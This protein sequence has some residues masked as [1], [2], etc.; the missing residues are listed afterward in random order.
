VE[1]S[2]KLRDLLGLVALTGAS[3]IINGYHPFSEDSETYLPAI[4]KLLNPRLFPVGTE[5]FQMHAHM[6]LFPRL[7]A[8]TVQY[9]HMSLAWA[10][11]LWQVISFFLFILACWKLAQ[12]ILP[13][14]ASCWA[15]VGLVVAL[16]TMPVAGTSLYLMDPFLNPRNIIAF[17]MV[18]AVL[19]VIE[20]RYVQASLFFLFGISVHPFM[21]AFSVTFCMLFVVMDERAVVRAP[22]IAVEE[23]EAEAAPAAPAIL[24]ASSF[25]GLFKPPSEAYD[26]VAVNH[27]YQF[28]ARWTWYEMLGAIAPVFIF[29]WF[30]A[31][32]HAR[33]LRNL[34]LLSRAMMIYGAVYFAIGLIVSVP[35]R[36]EVLSLL[37]PMRSLYLLYV[38]MLL[39][40]GGLL[41]EYLL[42]NRVWRWVAL[43]LPLSAGM[44]YAQR[45]L[46]PESSHIELPG[47][48]PANAWA[49]AF[50]WVRDNT[51]EQ[52]VFA[53]DP[54]Y[55][56][57]DGEDSN[58]FRA[59]ALRSQLADY[60]KDSG[61]VEL[62]PQLGGPWLDQVRAQTGID[63]FRLADFERLKQAYG[64]SWVVLK[65]PG[66]SELDC[67]YKNRA[68]AVCRLP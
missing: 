43:F 29:W 42:R 21:T 3:F 48:R 61:V 7:I 52:A 62:F 36:L 1:L 14:P 11:L 55:M 13:N 31:I 50:E 18:F 34:E 56:T 8:Y 20:R 27:R 33:R 6:T 32:A 44:C 38:L 57:I 67:P 63:H 60:V 15:G 10:L 39:I 64:V 45:A 66:N 4:E 54:K 30:G 28:L 2:L 24:L 37:Q 25:D 17:A 68:V 9:G 46:F 35:H 23:A 26:L 19:R 47:L 40:G 16:S 41:G 5:Y 58:G 22:E 53:I 49:Q 51:P 59:I 65:Q 12:R